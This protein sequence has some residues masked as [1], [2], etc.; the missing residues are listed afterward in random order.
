M[1]CHAGLERRPGAYTHAAEPDSAP[2]GRVVTV[3]I[4]LPMDPVFEFGESAAA[5]GTAAD[6][7]TSGVPLAAPMETVRT[8]VERILGGRYEHVSDIVVCSD[9]RYLGLIRME[10]LIAAEPSLTAGDLVDP[11]GPV[12]DPGEDQNA[13]AWRLVEHGERS[14]PVLDS[15]GQFVGLIPPERI[16]RVLL[17]HHERDLARLGGFLGEASQAR[18]SAEEPV[19]RRLWHRLPWLVVGL[20]GAMLAAE[21]LQ[22]FEAQ[23]GRTVALALFIPGIVYMADAVGTQTETLVVRGLSVGISIRSVV[24]REALTGMLVGCTLA[25]LLLPYLWWTQ[26]DAEVAIT[27]ALAILASCSIATIVAMLLPSL[28][29]RLGRDPAF[30]SGPLATVVQDL[31][32]LLAYL[33]IAAVI[34]R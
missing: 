13:A 26:H 32:S 25:T 34:I 19:L 10:D 14:L 11:A 9:G 15:N 17:E 24:R 2:S 21:L 20:V 28:L 18:I 5:L 22:A 16:M 6:H 8:V 27:V 4:L 3:P 33:A 31:L 1:A 12:V 23:L 29:Y 7:A 30:G